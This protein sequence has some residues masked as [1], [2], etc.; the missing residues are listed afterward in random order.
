MKKKLLLFSI[1]V[2][3]FISCNTNIKKIKEKRSDYLNKEVSVEGTVTSSG[4]F[5]RI[6]EIKQD[7]AT[8]YV[9]TEKE[10]PNEEEKITVTGVVKEKKMEIGGFR[11]MNELYIEEKSRE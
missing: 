7:E 11:L 3:F 4:T 9:F 8:I 1:P 5:P 6:Y 10:L 2:L